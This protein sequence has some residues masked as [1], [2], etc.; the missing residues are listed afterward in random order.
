MTEM[1]VSARI[2]RSTGKPELFFYS[3]GDLECYD[4][5][6][7]DCTITYM[8]NCT[9]PPKSIDEH[10]ACN[11]LFAQWVALP[12]GDPS[13]LVRRLTVGGAR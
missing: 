9:R 10:S 11:W 1:Q 4:G 2:N 12:G 5:Q 8:R 7:S 3:R 13:Y 6:H